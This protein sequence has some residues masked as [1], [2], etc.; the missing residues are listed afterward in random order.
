MNAGLSVSEARLVDTAE[1]ADGFSQSVTDNKAKLSDFQKAMEDMDKAA[2]RINGTLK[3]MSDRK[4]IEEAFKGAVDAAISIGQVTAAIYKYNEALDSLEQRRVN[5]VID[6][7]I[8]GK[9]IGVESAGVAD[10]QNQNSS[11]TGLGQF[12]ES[13]WLEMFK[14]YFPDQ[15]TG[16]TDAAILEL[17]KNADYSKQMVAF[18][19]QENAKAL[20]AA[21]V[22]VTDTNLYLAHFLGAGGATALLKAAPGTPVSSVLGADQIAANQSILSGKTTDQVIAWADQ[23]MG[24]GRTPEEMNREIAVAEELVAARRAAAEAARKEA[25]E[26]AKS[27]EAV[28]KSLA[29]L[30]FENDMLK[31][32]IAGKTKEAYIEEQIAR[33]K[34]GNKEFDAAAEARARSLLAS[35]Y[36][37]NEQLEKQKDTKTEI[38]GIEKTIADLQK[39]KTG[40]TDQRDILKARGDTAG[41][42]SIDGQ[43]SGVNSKLDEAIKKAIAF[44]QAMG[45]TEGAAAVAELQA[46]QMGLAAVNQNA[47]KFRFTYE[48]IKDSVFN[49]LESGVVDMFKAF[50][51]A[52]ANGENAVK[53]LGRAFRQFAAN[54]L[55]EMAQMILKQAL[56]NA[57]SG[58]TKAISGGL[59]GI[60]GV[61]VLTAHTGALIGASTGSST[62]S[63]SPAWFQNAVRYHSGG[64]AGLAPNEV[65][66]VLKK[67]E[68][69]LTQDNPRHARNAGASGG[70]GKSTKIVNAFDSASFLAEALKHTIGEEVILNYVRANPAAW[71][72]AMEG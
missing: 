52:V 71:K 40:L 61:P 11:A 34:E 15:A 57:L 56:F 62:I 39:Q 29:D 30:G 23:K 2:G 12:I 45:G 53:S 26:T 3:D 49:S 41:M 22:A 42:A 14:K 21:G 9:I 38:E 54:F 36:D 33:M 35:Q 31:M 68:E 55:M 48:E 1:A 20:Q 60:M 64:I 65:P 27:K 5:G 32:K 7:G 59:G 58:F 69:V 8:V 13:T 51:E 24:G 50:A 6:N 4:A 44:Y 25:E 16:M 47:E 18:Y 28:D 63:A 67:G 66:A 10:A 72:Q 70:G 17:R 19:L 37:L 43:L 46:M